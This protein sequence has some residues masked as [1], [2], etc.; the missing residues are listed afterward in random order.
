MLLWQ[1]LEVQFFCVCLAIED[2]FVTWN[3]KA[4]RLL[5]DQG[6]TV[7]KLEKKLGAKR[8]VFYNNFTKGALPAADV[9]VKIARALDVTAEW[10]FDD[11]LGF[12]V[13]DR[14]RR[15]QRERDLK[16]V[17]ALMHSQ[18]LDDERRAR[19]RENQP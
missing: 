6:L 8:G 12:D 5:N 18:I 17:E 1:W 9:G 3:E 11:S 14:H 4:S 10:L 13:L 16:I 15:S 19:E 7:A 2:P